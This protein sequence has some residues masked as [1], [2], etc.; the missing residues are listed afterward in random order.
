MVQARRKAKNIGT[1]ISRADALAEAYYNVTD[2]K[3]PFSIG[4]S[5]T[6][7]G[8]GVCIGTDIL[9]SFLEKTL[10]AN[11]E[12]ILGEDKLLQN[13][14]VQQ[15]ERIAYAEKAIVF[16]E[17]IEYSSQ[18]RRQRARWIN[19]YFENVKG[20]GQTFLKGIFSTNWNMIV[21]G[22]V[23]L[24]PPL[25]MNLALVIVLLIANLFISGITSMVLAVSLLLFILYF[26]L[27]IY[28]M[29]LAKYL[30]YLPTF[31]IEQFAALFA[32]RI[33][34]KQFGKTNTGAYLTIEDVLKNDT[35]P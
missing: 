34:K 28:Q 35:L 19:A 32:S 21:F 15:G 13:F 1:T 12:I 11:K 18:L 8:S 29:R 4:S 33:Y 9:T 3:L 20:A 7:A 2:R 31:I 6:I 5:A 25:F 17:K 26:V 16:D 24:R 22:L 10:L 14:L 23:T 30:A 27:L